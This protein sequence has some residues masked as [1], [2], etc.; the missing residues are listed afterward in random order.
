MQMLK[1]KISTKVHVP[2]TA[3]NNPA[4][5][6]KTENGGCLNTGTKKN[7][8]LK[9]RRTCVPRVTLTYRH[10]KKKQLLFSPYQHHHRR[11]PPS[12]TPIDVIVINR[13]QGV[14]PSDGGW[15]LD[16]QVLSAISLS[17]CLGV[18]RLRSDCSSLSFLGFPWG[19]CCDEVASCNTFQRFPPP[20]S[21]TVGIENPRSEFAVV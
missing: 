15:S 14:T 13:H 19:C 18:V 17:S 2:R 20:H 10:V 6:N 1:K 9:P 5:L 7:P 12:Q 11:L 4:N 8:H 21:G 3:L 16:C